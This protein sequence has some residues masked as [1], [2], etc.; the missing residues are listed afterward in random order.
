MERLLYIEDAGHD[1]IT[2]AGPG[3]SSRRP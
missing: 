2:L 1:L 3:A